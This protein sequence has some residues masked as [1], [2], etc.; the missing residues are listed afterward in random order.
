M[1]ESFGRM[2][3]RFPSF[4]PAPREAS[5]L[6]MGPHTRITFNRFRQPCPFMIKAHPP[7]RGAG[8]VLLA[9]KMNRNSFFPERR[10]ELRIVR[11]A[12]FLLNLFGVRRGALSF[13][14]LALS[15]LFLLFLAGYFFAPLL[16]SVSSR[17]FG[18]RYLL[19]F[20]EIIP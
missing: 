9:I 7:W 5:A 6:R 12:L 14:Q 20:N 8:S 4:R 15:S 19:S 18:Q 11:L 13:L 1:S 2:G 17:T 16:A 3:Q 10:N